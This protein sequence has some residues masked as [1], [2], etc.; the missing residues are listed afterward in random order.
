MIDKVISMKEQYITMCEGSF[1]T[2]G[3]KERLCRLMQDRAGALSLT[4]SYS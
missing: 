2:D 4:S 3:Y 1:L